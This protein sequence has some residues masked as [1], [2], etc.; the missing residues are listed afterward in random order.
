[1]FYLRCKRTNKVTR[2]QGYH[3]CQ[4]LSWTGTIIENILFLNYF[5][6]NVF[7]CPLVWLL[8][9]IIKS[10]AILSNYYLQQP[11]DTHS[12]VSIQKHPVTRFLHNLKPLRVLHSQRA[13]LLPVTLCRTKAGGGERSLLKPLSCGTSCLDT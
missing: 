12:L 1:M 3:I 13:G 4:Q 2:T 9:T 10:N 7:L 11:T 8:Q 5:L 6:C